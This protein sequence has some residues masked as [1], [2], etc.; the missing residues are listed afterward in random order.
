MGVAGRDVRVSTDSTINSGTRQDSS[1]VTAGPF[2]SAGVAQTTVVQFCHRT[3]SRSCGTSPPRP[4]PPHVGELDLPFLADVQPPRLDTLQASYRGQG[5]SER[6]ADFLAMPVRLSTAQVS[7]TCRKWSLYCI[8]CTERQIDPISIGD[9][10]DFFLHL[11]D[12]VSLV[13]TTIRTYKAAILSALKPR[14]PFSTSQLSALNRLLNSFHKRRRPKPCPV[15]E[16]DICLVLKA[17]WLPP[18]KPIHQASVEALT[19]K[20]LVLVA[21]AL[22]TQEGA[23]CSPLRSHPSSREMVFCVNIF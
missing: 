21:L 5:F 8:W 22:G 4:V 2:A 16:W 13:A 10:V 19:Y 6:A 17:F 15:P 23:Y 20:V 3:V 14:Q 7:D 11:L 1:L 12:G 18:V 9:L